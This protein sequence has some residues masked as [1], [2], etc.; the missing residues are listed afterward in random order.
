[1]VHRYAEILVCLQH[2]LLPCLRSIFEVENGLKNRGGQTEGC[3]PFREK[4]L[5]NVAANSFWGPVLNSIH[6]VMKF[7]LDPIRVLF[8]N[9][10]EC[11]WVAGHEQTNA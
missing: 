8:D 3:D 11:E 10:V 1:M 9:G 7:E 6:L 2:T 4:D 5:H